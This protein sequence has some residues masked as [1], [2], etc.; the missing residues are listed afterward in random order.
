METARAA[1]RMV[2]I[3]GRR[4]VFKA[5]CL[6]QS[7]VLWYLLRRQGISAELRIGVR[8]EMD[9]LQGHAWVE[10]AESAINE[11]TDVARGFA[12]L[13][14]AIVPGEV[15]MRALAKERADETAIR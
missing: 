5:T 6:P 8:K 13:D 1:G 9:R 2:K 12:V 11:D 7:L 4:G 14:R 10:V 3:A 15:M